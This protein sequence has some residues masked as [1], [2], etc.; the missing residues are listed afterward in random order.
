MLLAPENKE[1]KDQ[2]TENSK[3]EDN[4]TENEEELNKGAK[5]EDTSMQIG[6][7]SALLME[8]STGT[9]LFEQ[10]ADTKRPPASVTKIMTMLLIFDAVESKK[11]SLEDK[12]PVSEFAASMGGSQVFLETGETQ[13]VDTM[14]KC[15]SIASA[16]D[17]C[18]AMAEY[19]S[20]SEEAF[21]Q[22]MNKRA[23]ALGMHNT[24]FVNCN[25]LRCTGACTTARDIALM[26]RE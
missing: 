15:I 22:E 23:K 6:A 2:N 26:S 19:I 13:T 9:V 14:L 7:P 16:N 8:A 11:I 18:V 20:G 12:V 25:G 4:N 1:T 17:A 21:V 5:K 3:I 24:N 10:D